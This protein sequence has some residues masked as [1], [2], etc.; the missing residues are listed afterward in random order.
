MI[1]SLVAPLNSQGIVK[2]EQRETSWQQQQQQQQQKNLSI[3]LLSLPKSGKKKKNQNTQEE[4]YSRLRKPLNYDNACTPIS[5]RKSLRSSRNAA[6]ER[7]R[8]SH[9]SHARVPVRPDSKDVEHGTEI[10]PWNGPADSNN[11]DYD[12]YQIPIS[13]SLFHFF[14]LFL[15]SILWCSRD[16]D[17]PLPHLAKFWLL[18]NMKFKF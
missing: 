5:P 14:P 10:P 15:S 2:R 6:F 4:Q 13:F 9:E 8:A 12:T 16:C 17:H 18:K 11:H 3:C 1:N 7:P